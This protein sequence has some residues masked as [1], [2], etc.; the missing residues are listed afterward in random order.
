MSAFVYFAIPCGL[1]LLYNTQTIQWYAITKSL[2][3]DAMSL[4]NQR[5]GYIQSCEK[6]SNE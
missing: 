2:C 4:S 3:D 6:E 5:S 1:N